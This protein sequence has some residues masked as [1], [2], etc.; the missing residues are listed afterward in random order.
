MNPGL[1]GAVAALAWGGADF[2]ARF[3]GRALGQ[4]SA[5]LGMLL[6]GSV[7]MTIWLVATDLPVD[8]P[9]PA[10][11]LLIVGGVGVTGGTWLLYWGYVR[12]P[13][14][15]VSPITASYPVP[16]VAAAVALGARP[17]TLQWAAMVAVVAGVVIVARA[18]RQF[19]SVD[20]YDRASLRVTVAIAAGAALVFALALTTAQQAVPLYGEVQTLWAVRLISLLALL[21]AFL[22]PG[23]KF[24]LPPRWWPLIALQG[25]LDGGGYLAIYAGSTGAEAE[26]AAV[27][28][29][30]FMAV[31]VILARLFLGERM[32]LWHWAGVALIVAG[33]GALSS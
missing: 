21:P 26:L 15:I 31:T 33:G 13:V 16:I 8:L 30:G 17:T 7:V 3:T 28:A 6:V 1:W 29:A 25:L 14:S 4:T 27:V 2:T 9:G 23:Q 18:A 22:I 10:P 12:G 20:G 11:A 19:E 5:L 24:S 32:T